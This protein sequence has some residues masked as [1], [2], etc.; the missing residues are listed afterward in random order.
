MSSPPFVG[1]QNIIGVR[2]RSAV[3]EYAHHYWTARGNITPPNTRYY[4][5]AA[6]AIEIVATYIIGVN[7]GLLMHCRQHW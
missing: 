3:I 5:D 1:F 4:E 2:Q 6:I 7:I